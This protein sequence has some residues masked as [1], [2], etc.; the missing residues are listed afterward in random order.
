MSFAKLLEPI[1]CSNII[2]NFL[3]SHELLTP[4]QHGFRKKHSC[5]SQLLITV[6]DFLSAYDSKTQTDVGIL[7]FSRA[8]DTV[9]HERLLE[10]LAHYGIQGATNTW[11]RS[12]LTDRTMQVVVD[13]ETSSS[14][15]VISGVQQGTVLGPLLFLIFIN[16]LPN[17]VSE[18]TF[19]RLFADDCLVYRLIRSPDDQRILQE[20]LHRLHNWTKIWG[21]R[22]NPAKCQIMHLSRTKTVSKYYKLCNVILETVESAKYLAITISKDLRWHNHICA[23]AKKCNSTLHFIS[24]NL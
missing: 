5:E 12:F 20:D 1:I 2:I 11:I 22:F 21:M 4:L 19:I 18:G 3:E 13:G 10:K 14:A 24:R 6:D 7:D 9:P 8:F 17:L 15:P 16:D 23:V